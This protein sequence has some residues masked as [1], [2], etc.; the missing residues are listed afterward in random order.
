MRAP[1][2]NEQPAFRRPRRTIH[3]A[4]ICVVARRPAG[5]AGRD[6]TSPAASGQEGAGRRGPASPAPAQPAYPR[7][8]RNGGGNQRQD[9]YDDAAGRSHTAQAEGP[10]LR[11]KGP[12]APRGRL[13][14]CLTLKTPQ[15]ESSSHPHDPP[16]GDL[17]AP[18][19][20][21]SDGLRSGG[22]AETGADCRTFKNNP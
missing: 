5:N 13:Q 6:I 12:S 21:T 8:S 7:R 22:S 20:R 14:R 9:T 16:D 11:A 1:P 19:R 10:S 3:K 17:A 4:P 15:D 18:K 2:A